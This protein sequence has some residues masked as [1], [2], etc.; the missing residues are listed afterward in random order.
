MAT[1]A[2]F[3][4]IEV[5]NIGAYGRMVPVHGQAAPVNVGALWSTTVYTVPAGRILSLDTALIGWRSGTAPTLLQIVYYDAGGA[6]AGYVTRTVPAAVNVPEILSPHLWLPSGWTLVYAN[7]GGDA[8]T[9]MVW[10]FAGR[11]FDWT[12]FA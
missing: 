7:G 2:D 1:A 11:L 10:S 3:E 8:T 5:P 6:L 4:T 12:D 9:D